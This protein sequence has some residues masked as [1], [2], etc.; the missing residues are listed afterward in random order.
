MVYVY[1]NTMSICAPRYSEIDELD[2][3]IKIAFRASQFRENLPNLP[4]KEYSLVSNQSRDFCAKRMVE[5]EKY[6]RQLVQVNLF[7]LNFLFYFIFSWFIMLMIIVN[8]SKNWKKIKM[9]A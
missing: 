7:I 4:P 9:I 1:N 8:W 6:F 2:T 5:L 3:R